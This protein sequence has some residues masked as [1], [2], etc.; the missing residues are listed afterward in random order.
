MRICGS[1]AQQF[2]RCAQNRVALTKEGENAPRAPR[3]R[4]TMPRGAAAREAD[5]GCNSYAVTMPS[6][7]V[8]CHRP[9][10]KSGKST[11]ALRFA[12][13]RSLS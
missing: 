4:H 7:G 9:R 3:K 2:L 6:G 1:I 10:V 5:G 11:D 8:D 13:D 12:F